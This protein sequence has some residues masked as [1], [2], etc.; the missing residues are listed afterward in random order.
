MCDTQVT[1]TSLDII[2]Q[3]TSVPLSISLIVQKSKLNSV[4]HSSHLPQQ[5]RDPS[6]LVAFFLKLTSSSLS[7]HCSSVVCSK[8][9]RWLPGI[10]A[11]WC[12]ITSTRQ[13]TGLGNECTHHK[14]SRVTSPQQPLLTFI[15]LPLLMQSSVSSPVPRAHT[16]EL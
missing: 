4:A 7:A 9:L 1:M 12:K 10:L 14:L 11:N 16:H 5:K 8:H 3:K 2:K 13:S 6:S 15:R